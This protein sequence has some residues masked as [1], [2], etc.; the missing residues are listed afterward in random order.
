MLVFNETGLQLLYNFNLVKNEIYITNCFT[1][2]EPDCKEETQGFFRKNVDFTPLASWLHEGTL[3][4]TA[5]Q[6]CQSRDKPQAGS[7][8]CFKNMFH[9]YWSLPVVIVWLN[10]S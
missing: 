4:S 5:A 3:H 10:I 7:A 6:A 1:S 9:C 8:Q 2:S